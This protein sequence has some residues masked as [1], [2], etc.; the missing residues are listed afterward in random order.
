[1]EAVVTGSD[2]V[3]DGGDHGPGWSFGAFLRGPGGGGFDV[4][5]GTVVVGIEVAGHDLFA[6]FGP[7]DVGV[8]KVQGI[9]DLGADLG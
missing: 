6:V 3:L 7:G 5:L 2:E 9:Q 8:V 4:L 1:V